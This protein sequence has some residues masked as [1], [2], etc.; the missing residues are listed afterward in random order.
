M[1]MND[2]TIGQAA[3][4]AGVSVETMRYYERRG[5]IPEPPRKR[6]GYRQYPRSTIATLRSILKAKDLGF[7]L[8]EIR[9][10]LFIHLVP[11]ATKADVKARAERKIYEISNKIA[12]LKRMK[13]ALV[14]LSATCDGVGPIEEC[15][16]LKALG[17]DEDDAVV[18]YSHDAMC[19]HV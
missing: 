5:L 10:L 9:E 13:K 15:P 4:L 8:E 17:E 2:L 1:T 12:D 3:K 7:T 19:H 6:S 14:E 16:I 11:G 18:D